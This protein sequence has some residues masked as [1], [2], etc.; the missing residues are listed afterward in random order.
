MLSCFQSCHNCCIRLSPN[1]LSCLRANTGWICR[2]RGI[3]NEIKLS[4]CSLYQRR[5]S[6]NFDLSDLRKKT[7]LLFYLVEKVFK[8]CLG[9][10]V[11]K[12]SVL[13]YQTLHHKTSYFTCE[14]QYSFWWT[15]WNAALTFGSVYYMI[16]L[17]YSSSNVCTQC[18]RKC[19]TLWISVSTWKNI[20]WC[21]S[22]NKSQ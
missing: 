21:F 16:K 20:R 1:Y 9:S 8:R 5:N 6:G 22:R 7:A 18:S 17:W 19:I 15:V 12:L 14:L 4:L 2:F 13:D 3:F 11:D 10:C